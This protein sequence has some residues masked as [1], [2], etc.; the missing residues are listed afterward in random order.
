M[1]SSQLASQKCSAI[2]HN[3]KQWAQRSG[4][5]FT[6]PFS[7]AARSFSLKWRVFLGQIILIDHF[8]SIRMVD[9]VLVCFAIFITN[10]VLLKR[11]AFFNLWHSALNAVLHPVETDKRHEKESHDSSSANAFSCISENAETDIFT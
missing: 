2:K 1:R 6:Q 9:R 10:P 7:S 8:I 4:V 11:P 5:F 3:L